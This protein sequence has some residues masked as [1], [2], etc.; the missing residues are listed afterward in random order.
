MSVF[1]NPNTTQTCPEDMLNAKTWSKTKLISASV[2]ASAMCKK[3]RATE[4][5]SVLK[6][7]YPAIESLKYKNGCNSGIEG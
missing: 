7:S 6:K 3:A 1:G 2:E 4:Q 5:E